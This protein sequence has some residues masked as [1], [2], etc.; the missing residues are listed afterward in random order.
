MRRS[1]ERIR[2]I[3]AALVACALALSLAYTT[4]AVGGTAKAQGLMPPS[5]VLAVGG[6]AMAAAA[7]ALEHGLDAR[8]DAVAGRS[9]R[10][11]IDR[12]FSAR[13]AGGLPASVIVGL[14]EDGPVTAGQLGRLRAALRGVPYV[15]LV[16]MRERSAPWQTQVNDAL[17]R[18]VRSWPAATLANWFAASA[19]RG[20][21]A[22][23]MPTR[24]G[25]RE[26]ATVVERALARIVTH[27]QTTMISDSVAAAIHYV[28]QAQEALTA[29]IHVRLD[30]AVCR[31]LVQP[32]CSYQGAAPPTALQTITALGRSL[33]SVLVIDCGYN[34]DSSGYAGWID[35][36]MRAAV[37]QGAQEVIWVTLR[38]S[39]PYPALYAE[40]D[41]QIDQAAARWPQLRV[42]DWNA[43]SAAAPWFVDGP[44]L[45][46]AGAVALAQFLRG[47]IGPA[48]Y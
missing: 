43:F 23:G 35:E 30:L 29:G 37:A 32:S 40:I 48:R 34:D 41:A 3:A 10:A 16:T 25:A 46:D 8:V 14:G 12:L 44:H 47:Y 18:A 20:L 22:A 19:A 7:P 5:G 28:P 26:Y 38:Q 15:V 4:V 21:L 1:H 6:A 39:P 36:I 42:A 13:A 2:R 33:G 27:T 9:N 24:A 11:L 45:T 17:A 31:R